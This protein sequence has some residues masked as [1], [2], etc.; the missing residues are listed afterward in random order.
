MY[1]IHGFCH[2]G[3]YHLFSFQKTYIF[4]GILFCKYV[5]IEQTSVDVDETLNLSEK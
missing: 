1:S 3:H 5:A 2:L 4:V